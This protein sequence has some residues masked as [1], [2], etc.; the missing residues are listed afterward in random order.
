MLFSR[1]K[2]YTE[3][4]SFSKLQY[5][6]LLTVKL[7]VMQNGDSLKKRK[8]TL[9]L[10]VSSRLHAALRKHSIKTAD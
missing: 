4:T 2:P 1:L 8:I 3:I 9:R 6:I 10:R 7:T 5:V